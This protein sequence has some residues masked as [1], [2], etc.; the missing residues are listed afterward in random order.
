M[1]ALVFR[2]T[3]FI[4]EENF[5]FFVQELVFSEVHRSFKVLIKGIHST[6]VLTERKQRTS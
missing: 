6:L 3:N 2:N 1:K 4:E 5:N